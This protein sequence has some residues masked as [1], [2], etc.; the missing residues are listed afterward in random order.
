M[1]TSSGQNSKELGLVFAFDTGDLYNSYLGEPTTNLLPSPTYNAYPTYGNGWSTYNTNQYCGNNGCAVFWDIPAV[2]SVSN[3]IVTTVSAHPIRSFDVIR[4]ETT[5]GGLTANVDYLA[6]KISD[7]QFSLH[8]YNSSQDGSQGYIN[9]VTGGHKV[10]D[11]YWLDER[12]SVN[13]SG[14]PTKWWGAPHLPNSGIVKEVI[15]KGFDLFPTPTNC[16]RL[17]WSRPD[18]VTD[19]MAYG[20]DPYVVIGQPVT[21]SFWARAVTSSAVGQSINF[22]NYN[23]G[24]PSGY[25]Y[26]GMSVTWGA[27]GKWVRNSYTI[28]PTH[29]YLISYWFPS[30]GNMKVDIADIQ[31]EQKPHVTPFTIGSRT[32]VNSLLDL[33]G[34]HTIDLNTCSFTSTGHPTLDGTD[35]RID[36][37]NV[38]DYFTPSAKAITVEAVFKITPGASGPMGPIFENYR[39]N[40]WY[41]YGDDTVYGSVRTGPP[42]TSGYQSAIGFFSNVSCSSKGNYNH[43]VLVYET[44]GGS[45]GRMTFYVNGKYAGMSE[46]LKMGSYPLYASWIGQSYH[47]GYG[48]YKLIGEVNVLRIYTRALTSNEI[49]PNYKSYKTRFN[50][51]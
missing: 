21:V 7:T 4:P 18:G 8:A 5:G 11:S 16:L 27:L 10:H 26:F 48:T 40:F 25:S 23:Y 13:A 42:E 20:V 12:V 31:I 6:K 29:N 46:G 47:G 44:L 22:S 34:N 50:L 1:P 32:N 14:F 37:G 49:I 33:T 38:S 39:F 30:T 43:V 24:G 28:T 19:G 35:D 51:V 17:H 45:N 15:P 2:A 3:N 36:L 41:N 9:P